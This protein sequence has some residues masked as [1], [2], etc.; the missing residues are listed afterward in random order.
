MIVFYFYLSSGRLPFD[1]PHISW[2]LT[3]SGFLS[4][5]S[6]F[7]VFLSYLFAFFPACLLPF[8]FLRFSFFSRSLPLCFLVFFLVILQTPL[9][10]VSRAVN[11][12]HSRTL[13][14]PSLLIQCH[15]WTQISLLSLP[16]LTVC[17]CADQVEMLSQPLGSSAKRSHIFTYRKGCIILSISLKSTIC[18][19]ST[20]SAHLLLTVMLGSDLDVL[21]F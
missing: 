21:L 7:H 9:L 14:G 15:T 6:S 16:Y 20:S 3:E 1:G 19:V 13:C 8:M 10:A 17:F 18:S 2:L 11:C 4:A 5:V 12:G